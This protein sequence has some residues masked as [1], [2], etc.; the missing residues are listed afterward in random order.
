MLEEAGAQLLFLRP[1]RF[2]KSL[3]LSMLENYYDIAKADQFE[4]LFGKLAVGKKP[5]K[6]RNQYFVLK[7]DF[8]MISP[9]GEAEDIQRSLHRS[10]NA[11]IEN[12]AVYYKE[13]LPAEIKI[14]PVDATISFRSLLS[15]V[16]QTQH[17]LYLLIDEYDNFANEIFMGERETDNDR[18][19]ALLHGEGVIKTLFKVIK[20]ASGGR[21]L[22]RVFITGVLPIALDDVTSG[23]NI[24]ED[25]YLDPDF[26]DLC[27][28]TE[29]EISD[30]CRR[31]AE[32]RN[33]P[34]ESAIEALSM[35]RTF[36]DGYCFSYDSENKIYNPWMALYCLEHF[37]KTGRSPRKMPDTN[38]AM[39]RGKI[40]YI[41]KLPNGK[42]MILNALDEK[43]PISIIELADRFGVEDL[44][45][46]DKD[47]ISMASLLYYFGVLTMGGTTSMGK[48]ILRT[49]NFVVR[50]LYVEQIRKMLLPDPGHMKDS[51]QAAERIYQSGDI[52]P[53]CDFFEKCCLKVFD[54]P[55]YRWA[56]ELTIKTSFMTLLFND[57][58]YIID[59]ETELERSYA[60]LTMIVRPDMRGNQLLD[61]LI[62]FKFIGLSD[63]GMTGRE[64]KESDLDSLLSS[65]LVQQTLE[66]SRTELEIYKGVLESKY[67]E[68]L[69]LRSY[70]VIALG[71]DRLIWKEYKDRDR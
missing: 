35:M 16:K 46:A 68:V 10:L 48:L 13:L 54:N 9:R 22:D 67:G 15:A 40:Y 20:A 8:S 47:D 52:Q 42:K 4:K 63:I 33:L 24:A 14:E 71:F 44:L 51:R 3:L 26:N 28:F 18:Y 23:Y 37:Q 19:K 31:I 57:T 32:E 39:D 38:L 27:G 59:S 2:G 50:K 21:G 60:D 58:F 30:A 17:R 55:D 69:N 56:N 49:P 6:H 36:Y 64:V 1:R 11:D 45:S 7:W 5:T 66:E 12:F 65:T 70:S 62:E 25:I 61:I 43:R 34:G 53:L 29:S 41:S